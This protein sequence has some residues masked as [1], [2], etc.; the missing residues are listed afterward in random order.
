M[1]VG[2][3]VAALTGIPAGRIVDHFGTRRMTAVGLLGT[4]P[5]SAMLSIMLRSS[6]LPAMSHP[7]P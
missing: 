3:L 1:S 7:W 5:G 4:T 2:P 6:E